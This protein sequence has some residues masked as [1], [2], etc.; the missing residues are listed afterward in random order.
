MLFRN[1]LLKTQCEDYLVL[2]VQAARLF[3]SGFTFALQDRSAEFHRQ[4]QE[5]RQVERQSLAQRRA[6][7]ASLARHGPL[8]RP[9]PLDAGTLEQIGMT[10]R[11]LTALLRKFAVEQPAPALE[12]N[13]LLIEL[14]ESAEQ[15]VIR[16]AAA[17]RA[18]LAHDAGASALA[19]DVR[20]QAEQVR[21]AGEQYARV[22]YRLD[23]RLSHKMQLHDFAERIES[24]ADT[25]ASA[26]DRAIA[27]RGGAVV[28]FGGWAITR[29]AAGL[30]LVSALALSASA[31]LLL[32]LT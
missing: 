16:M 22:L 6:L 23:L 24:V 26:S 18:Q 27:P 17:L 1:D 21:N 3:C 14:A 15:A 25:A 29:S 9:Y 4:L 10:V 20:T 5:L 11:Q 19:D 12:G 8:G 30:L 28:S 32:T 7:L 2:A 13:A 31:V